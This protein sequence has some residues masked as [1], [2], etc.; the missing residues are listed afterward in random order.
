M[1]LTNNAV[2]AFIV[3]E[4]ATL[5]TAERRLAAELSGVSGEKAGDIASRMTLLQARL[6]EFDRLLDEL[7]NTPVLAA[8]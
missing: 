1:N 7:D 6:D 2:D 8:A 5:R 4:L 3:H